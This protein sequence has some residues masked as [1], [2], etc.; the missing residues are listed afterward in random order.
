MSAMV[1]LQGVKSGGTLFREVPLT[2]FPLKGSKGTFYVHCGTLCS[3]GLHHG[4]SSLT[5]HGD[6]L[7]T[8]DLNNDFIHH[9]FRTYCPC[10]LKEKTIIY[11]LGNSLIN[12]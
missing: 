3:Y 11:D 7:L 5:C 4:W 1:M 10:C 6:R 2:D 12:L 9:T 8:C